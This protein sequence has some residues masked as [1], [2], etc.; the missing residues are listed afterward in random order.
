MTSRVCTR[1]NKTLPVGDLVA[2]AVKEIKRRA[3]E[4]SDKNAKNKD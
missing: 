4:R 2:D 3:K 1:T